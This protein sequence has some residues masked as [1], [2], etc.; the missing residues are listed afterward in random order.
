[1][2]E[3][4]IKALAAELGLDPKRVRLFK[5]W[6]FEDMGRCYRFRYSF[7]GKHIDYSFCLSNDEIANGHEAFGVKFYVNK[8]MRELAE[9]LAQ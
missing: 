8:G 4:E 3:E 5:P 9:K 7:G 6:Q 2:S 1:M